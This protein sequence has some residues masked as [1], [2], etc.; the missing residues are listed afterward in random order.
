MAAILVAIIVFSVL[1]LANKMQSD[2]ASSDNVPAP[3]QNEEEMSPTVTEQPSPTLE[4]TLEPVLGAEPEPTPTMA[5]PVPP[6]LTP[7]PATPSPVPPLTVIEGPV[8]VINDRTITVFD[9]NIQVDPNDPI[10]LELEVGDVVRVEG[11]AEFDGTVVVIA[12][13]NIVVVEYDDILIP[14]PAGCK[15]TGFGNGRIRCKGSKRTSR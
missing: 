7:I 13:V 11:V 12:A 6:T 8:T 1:L 9:M 3:T 2:P 14:L 5:S 4:F 15:L 10:L